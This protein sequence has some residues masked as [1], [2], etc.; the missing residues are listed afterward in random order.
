MAAFVVRSPF[1]RSEYDGPVA[2]ALYAHRGAAAELP[3]NTLPAFRRAMERGA[4][5]IETDAHL[6]RDGHVV[7]SHD[8]TGAR[9]AGVPYGIADS[10]LEQ[11]RTWNV[12][13]GHPGSFTIPTLEEALEDLPGVP[14]N[15]DCKAPGRDA[16]ALLVGIVRRIGA[17][18]RVLI[19]SFRS[20]TLRHVRRLGYEGKTS[21]GQSEIFRVALMPR[22]LLRALPLHGNAA[23]VPTRAFGLRFDTRRFV[24][25]CHALGLVVHYWTIDDPLEA[26][27]LADLGADGIM[28]D[29]PRLVAPALGL[30]G[31]GG[32]STP[33]PT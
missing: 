4:T 11:V 21:L 30:P 12:A 18:E 13:R 25:K 10:T 1:A 7:L 2:I 23:Q 16:A 6:T 8:A 24:D 31:A 32:R 3:E 27:R 15:V 33:E 20:R 9:A 14:F 29:D 19:A 5:A 26:R 22:P 28:T 17:E